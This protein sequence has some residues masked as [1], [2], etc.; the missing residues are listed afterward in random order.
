MRRI[1]RRIRDRFL[2]ILRLEI[3]EHRQF[4][5]GHLERIENFLDNHT[6]LLNQQ[7]IVLE[8]LGSKLQLLEILARPAGMIGQ[9]DIT[10]V[11]VTGDATPVTDTAPAFAAILDRMAEVSTALEDLRS[12]RGRDMLLARLPASGAGEPLVSDATTLTSLVE[13]QAGAID[14]LTVILQDVRSQF[15]SMTAVVAAA[16]VDTMKSRIDTLFGHVSNVENALSNIAT[17]VS[18]QH[19]SLAIV[20]AIKASLD[21]KVDFAG[22]VASIEGIQTSLATL[23]SEQRQSKTA[24]DG[25]KAWADTW[26]ATGTTANDMDAAPANTDRLA[27]MIESQG[28]TIDGIA[29]LLQ[30]VRSNL[31]GSART[32]DDS[33]AHLLSDRVET[34]I[35]HVAN[36]ENALSNIAT[37]VSEQHRSLAIVDEIRASLD[38]KADFA[39]SNAKSFDGIDAAIQG[40][41]SIL[42]EGV[43]VRPD[44]SLGTLKSRVETLFGHVANVENGMNNIASLV[45]QQH[46]ATLGRPSDSAT[47][48]RQFLAIN[49]MVERLRRPLESRGSEARGSSY[50]P[51]KPRP[52]DA[53][54]AAMEKLGPNA[55]PIWAKLFRNSEMSYTSDPVASCS[56]WGNLYAEAFRDFCSLYLQGRVLDIGCGPNGRPLY[57]NGYPSNCISV[58]EPLPMRTKVDFEV[59]RGFAEFLP[60]PVGSFHTVIAS[61]SLDH[62]LSLEKALSEVHSMLV[63]GGSFLVWIASI[64]GAPRYNPSALHL[65]A[66][67]EFHLFHIDAA[68]FEPMMSGRFAIAEKLTFPAGSY[69][70]VFYRFVKISGED[71][72]SQAARTGRTGQ[73][74]LG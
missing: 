14:G 16:N 70:H 17:L 57:L 32:T 50:H 24:I 4:T 47:A 36:V 33:D 72:V 35:G 73:P 44:G 48:G 61:S 67:D 2:G 31:E 43:R 66:F 55:F 64:P 51:A 68:W 7:T 69:D 56:T 34:L 39:V 26:P 60:W 10:A 18:E 13:M 63:P 42:E 11:G 21:T 15:E 6:A 45:S 37:L 12:E 49:A 38:A 30:E 58:I 40:V 3:A 74:A 8:R 53:Y 41:R 22:S 29:V 9:P 52:F 46:A 28:G 19:R 54:V 71:T 65:Q 25:I 62:T 27:G 20:D 59:V 1:F 23:A 5:Q